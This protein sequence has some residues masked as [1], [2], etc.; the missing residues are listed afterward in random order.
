VELNEFMCGIDGRV[1]KEVSKREARDVHRFWGG[2]LGVNV[3][4]SA[5]R[6]IAGGGAAAASIAAAFSVVSKVL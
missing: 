3:G 4:S 1:M 5:V 2:C 6:V